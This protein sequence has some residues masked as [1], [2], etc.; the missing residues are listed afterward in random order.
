M[1]PRSLPA[2]WLALLLLPLACLAQESPSPTLAKL[3]QSG[4]ITL[5]YRSAS[6]PFSYLDAQLQPIGFTMDICHQVVKAL[7]RQP[8]LADLE[9]RLLPVSSGTRLPLVANRSVDIECGITTNTAERQKNVGFSLTYFV[10]E[11]RLLSKRSRPIAQIEALRGQAVASTL[12]TTSIQLL[13][14]L[15]R[16]QGLNLRILA[17]LDDVDSVRLLD[18]DQAL[19]FAMDDVLLRGLLATKPNATDYLVSEQPLSVE[20]YGLPLPP[21][22]PQFKKLVDQALRELFASGE[23]AQLYKR[24]FQSPVP[25]QGV[26]LNL[27]MPKA[28]ARAVKEPTDSPDPA[29]YR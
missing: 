25:P 27:S 16:S 26:N 28:L 29:R 3:R 9:V 1:T 20:P 15:N 10:A 24:W 8:G 18:S 11:S 6:L 5:G 2:L 17:G 13:Q 22:D 23:F 4:V 7:R 14:E 12:G 19:A 21:G